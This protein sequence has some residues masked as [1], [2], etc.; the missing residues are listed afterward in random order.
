MGK[1]LIRINTNLTFNEFSSLSNNKNI[2]FSSEFY[3]K[4]Q[5][6][7]DCIALKEMTFNILLPFLKNYQLS[8]EDEGDNVIRIFGE[9]IG[10]ITGE[11]LF[12]YYNEY[13]IVR[14]IKNFHF[15]S[16]RSPLRKFNDI[17][18]IKQ[19]ESLCCQYSVEEMLLY[20]CNGIDNFNK[21]IKSMK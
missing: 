13:A 3:S 20:V 19:L 4:E 17:C 6:K 8:G 21:I 14:N 12:R 15:A 18:V 5:I 11:L 10:R 16:F 1:T 7:R 2:P 9:F